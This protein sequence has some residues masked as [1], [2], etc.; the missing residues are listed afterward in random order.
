MNTVHPL[1]TYSLQQPLVETHVQT[2]AGDSHVLMT[3]HASYYS[4]KIN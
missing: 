2:V 1:H 3:K 4:I